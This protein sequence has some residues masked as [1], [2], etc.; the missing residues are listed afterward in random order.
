LIVGFLSFFATIKK[1]NIIDKKMFIS[2]LINIPLTSIVL[3]FILIIGLI[4]VD[5]LA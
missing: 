2:S 1:K 3:V 5:T 4:P